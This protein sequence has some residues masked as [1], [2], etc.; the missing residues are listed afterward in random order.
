[1]TVFN[2]D[3][4]IAQSWGSPGQGDGQLQ[5]PWGVAVAPNGD[6]YV[7]DTWNH[8]VQRF[9]ST[10]K[11]LGKWGKLGDAR[12]GV[13]GEPGVFWG[14]RSIAIS[15]QGEVYV[16]DTGNKRVQVFDLQGNFRRM[17]GGEGTQPG[18]FREPVG[19]ALDN[20]GNLLVADAWNQ[21]VQRLDPAGRPLE[22]FAVS[23]GWESQSITNKPYL[24]F[25]SQG[26]IIATLPDMGRVMVFGASGN[27]VSQFQLPQDGT[28]V[29]IYTG[30]DGRLYVADA[31]NGV[32]VAY[33]LP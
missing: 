23:A 1:V 20:E 13:D 24:A 12:G 15:S 18:Q 14:P 10:G 26:R 33:P 4:S 16:S 21:R 19:L 27:T 9:D 6:V 8:R 17:F 30:K 11:F 2:S 29:G 32:I 28:P 5:E 25:D 22:D 31:R 3:G 7:A